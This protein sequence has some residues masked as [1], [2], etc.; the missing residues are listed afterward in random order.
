MLNPDFISWYAHQVAIG[1][2]LGSIEKAYSL[3]SNIDVN[4]LNEYKLQVPYQQVDVIGNNEKVEKAQY[5]KYWYD[6]TYV[7]ESEVINLIRNELGLKAG[8][9]S[10]VIIDG[11]IT[12]VIIVNSFL[13]FSYYKSVPQTLAHNSLDLIIFDVKDFDE[14]L[15]YDSVNS[16][17]V[18]KKEGYYLIN[19][20]VR[21]AT[22]VKNNYQI[23]AELHLN[24]VSHLTSDC[25]SYSGIYPSNYLFGIFKLNIGDILLVK[26]V[27]LTTVNLNT[28][29]SY[30]TFFSVAKLI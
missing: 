2:D 11:K 8:D 13:K 30:R 17:F 12:P 23:R 22:T 27:Q 1:N 5:K 15:D 19:S 18:V 29:S 28:D 4:I 21:W 26:A 9:F 20:V 24:G 7:T 25:M 10:K 14:N 16:Q 6:R 3:W